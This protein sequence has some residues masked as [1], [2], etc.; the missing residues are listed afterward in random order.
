MLLRRPFGGSFV[1]LIPFYKMD[2]GNFSLGIE[3]NQ[4]LKL[5]C[6]SSTIFSIIPSKTGMNEGAR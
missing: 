5:L 1:T 4:I 2:T 6:L 3:V